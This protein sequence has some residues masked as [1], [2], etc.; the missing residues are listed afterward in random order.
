[1]LYLNDYFWPFSWVVSIIP[2]AHGFKLY[3]R[4]TI[5]PIFI[6]P[7][8]NSFIPLLYRTCNNS[9]FPPFIYRIL[10]SLIHSALLLWKQSSTFSFNVASFLPSNSADVI[11]TP[12][13][14]EKQPILPSYVKCFGWS[15]AAKQ[16]NWT[17]GSQGIQST[18]HNTHHFI[19]YTSS[20]GFCTR[21]SFLNH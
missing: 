3:R 12:F 19:H 16:N 2:N 14:N 10:L 15:Y 5:S 17:S 4:W 7:F 11:P 6:V 1:M 18:L 8:W 20:N 13:W 21:I 9:R